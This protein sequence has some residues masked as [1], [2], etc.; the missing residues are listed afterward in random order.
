MMNLATILERQVAGKALKG[1]CYFSPPSTV[2]WAR[3]FNLPLFRLA[4]LNPF[5]YRAVI[6]LLLGVN[7]VLMWRF[8][9][10]SHPRIIGAAFVAAFRG[11]NHGFLCGFHV[12]SAVIY[13]IL[14]FFFYFAAFV[15]YLRIR[16]Q[17]R[18]LTWK[19]SAAVLLCMY[20][21]RAEFQGEC[22]LRSPFSC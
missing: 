8:A 7:V 16:S 14:C 12:I 19:Q 11:H 17:G 20:I 5:P 15:V 6:F 13:D 3:H 9:A 18:L 22:R 10:L 2:P 1:I 21:W 4:G